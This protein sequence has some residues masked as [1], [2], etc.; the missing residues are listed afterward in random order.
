[1]KCCAIVDTTRSF[2]A[3]GI[4]ACGAVTVTHGFET[5]KI[6][7]A[8]NAVSAHGH[9]VDE[10]LDYNCRESC[11]RKKQHRGCTRGCS[12]VSR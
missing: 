12:M 2:I 10:C 9:G 8:K 1:M 5:V 4:A 11:S 3:G 6:R 7:C